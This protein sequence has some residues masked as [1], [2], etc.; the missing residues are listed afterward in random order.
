MTRKLLAASA[1]VVILLGACGDDDKASES[2][3]APAASAAESTAAETTVAA[4][5]ETTADAGTTPETTADAAPTSGMIQK[6]GECGLGT[7]EEATGEPIKLGGMATNVPGIDFTWIPK[8]ASIYFDC[9]NA[10]GGINGQP[11]E[12]SFEEEQ[13][14][15]QQI[16]SLAT[17]LVEEDEVLGIVGNTSISECGVNGEYYK[18]QGYFAIIAGVSPDCFSQPNFS[19]LN[20]GP[21]YSTLGGAQAAINA[22][23][24]GKMVVVSPNA[25]GMDFNN[26]G[27]M[28]YAVSKGLEAVGRLEEVPFADP[29]GLAQAIV[30]EAGEGGAVVLNFTGPTVVPLLQAIEQQGLIDQVKWGSSTPPND[31]TVAAAVS[32]AWNDKFLIN[33]EFNLLDSGLP[34]QD[35][36]NALYEAASPDFPI[37]SFAQMGYLIGR[38]TT[39]ALLSID[40]DVT[41]ESVNEAIK[42]IKGF[43]S[44]LLCKPWYYDS[45]TGSN[46]S[47]NTDRTV[48]PRDGKIVQIEDCFDVAALEGN[49]LDQIRANEG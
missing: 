31:P 9:V 35:H 42:N 46:V 22:G 7:G 41:K 19:A 18:E 34:D 4:A 44:D 32:A 33:A 40:G 3:A 43:E 12:Y 14:D 21:Y 45:G 8:M 39:E 17:K 16:A 28:D 30:A 1:A 6:S 2:T 26:S 48:A 24:T 47:N 20:M 29:S 38:A 5:P 11:I 13:I 10:N 49:P 27:A 23:A 25:P 15:A 36:M 37:S